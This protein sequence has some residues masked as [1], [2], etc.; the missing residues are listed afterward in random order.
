MKSD[1]TAI[2][3]FL[4][5][6]LL[7]GLMWCQFPV[8][9][10]TQPERVAQTQVIAQAQTAAQ[11]VAQAAPA[12]P[13]L[14][15]SFLEKL[16]RFQAD[17]SLQELVEEDLRK[18]IV[19]RAQIQTE[20]DRA[21]S[22][23]TTLLNVL[24]AVLTSLPIVVAISIWLLRRSI[25]NQMVTETKRQLRVEVEKQLEEEVVAEF[26]QQITALKAEF[27]DQLAQLKS[28][29]L[30]AQTEKDRIIQELAEIV[31]SSMRD[32]AS[33]ETQQ[34]IQALTQQLE[35]LK[36]AHAPLSFTANDYVE[37]GRALY[38][39]GRYDDAIALQDRALQ[40]EPSNAKAWLSKGIALAK[41][42]RFEDALIAYEQAIA[43][44]SDLLEAWFSKGFALTKLQRWT[45]A[46]IAYE[47]VTQIKPDFYLA[48]LSI[49]RCYALQGKIE[50]LWEPVQKAIELNGDKSKEVLKTDSAFDVI[51]GN[52]QFKQLV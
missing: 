43:V 15:T 25:V 10:L 28:L 20:V 44:K 42:Q 8:A 18:S 50:L 36:S 14:P 37:Q 31:P 51:R 22:H 45:E 19:I 32:A 33:P 21:F 1:R 39:E 48:W 3:I 9:G 24:I 11:A 4:L 16:Q 5:T 6:G 52:E 49:A 23:T 27:T 13:S 2:A 26:K 35:R 38:V 30:D 17:R 7:T 29:F 41:L 46:M 12:T 47:T 34:K 40:M